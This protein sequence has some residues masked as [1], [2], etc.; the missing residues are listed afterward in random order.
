VALACY[1][2]F[3]LFGITLMGVILSDFK[4]SSC[5][6]FLLSDVE[7][8]EGR[9]V[10]MSDPYRGSGGCGN[11]IGP[12]CKIE[13]NDKQGCKQFFYV[14]EQRYF[15]GKKIGD[16][17]TFKTDGNKI[18]IENYNDAIGLLGFSFFSAIM[19]PF[20]VLSGSLLRNYQNEQ[21]R[22]KE[23]V[24]LII[25]RVLMLCGAS[26]AF[27]MTTLWMKDDFFPQNGKIESARIFS[28]DQSKRDLLIRVRSSVDGREAV[29]TQAL[30]YPLPLLST[31]QEVEVFFPE[32]D[33]PRL[34]SS[35]AKKAVHTALFFLSSYLLFVSV[36]AFFRKRKSCE[37]SVPKED[38]VELPPFQPYKG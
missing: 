26:A 29:L 15:F 33:S 21:Y 20:I 2:L 19:F 3:S 8:V 14:A 7:T 35:D 18:I 34:V 31:G 10:G 6:S 24:A 11:P 5:C 37:I 32:G 16:S 22:G 30:N 12:L 4:V 28:I 23:K 1:F 9:I 13:Y 17:I 36:S 25:V 38:D 27:Y